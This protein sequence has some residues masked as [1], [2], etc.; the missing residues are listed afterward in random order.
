[1]AV[2]RMASE[3]EQ[4]LNNVYQQAGVKRQNPKV[5]DELAKSEAVRAQA[6]EKVQT[7]KLAVEE[8]QIAKIKGSPAGNEFSVKTPDDEKLPIKGRYRVVE[9]ADLLSSR[10]EGYDAALQPRDRARAAS[11]QQI[12]TIATRL[13]PELLGDSLTSDT[14]SP[15][16]DSRG[17]VLSGNGRTEAI[18]QAYG[19]EDNR[20]GAYKDHLVANADAY[21]L[22]SDQINGM[23]N[24]VLVREATDFGKLSAEEF[25]RRSNKQQV[26]GMSDAENASADAKFLI[27]NPDVFQLLNPSESGDVL[28]ASNREFVSKFIDS[29]GDRA[30]LVSKDGSGYN[31]AKLTPRIRNAILAAVVGPDNRPLIDALVEDNEGIKKVTASLL[32]VAPKLARLQGGDYDI[33]PDLT[34]ALT[35]LTALRQSGDTVENFLGQQTLFGDAARTAASDLILRTLAG[36]KSTKAINEFLG[37]YADLAG[38]I[39]T[40]T[41]DMFNVE[42]PTRDE[43]LTKASASKPAADSGQADLALGKPPASDGKPGQAPAPA[44]E[45]PAKV[46]P[47]QAKLDAALSP[48]ERAELDAIEKELKAKADIKSAIGNSGKFS[49]QD[50]SLLGTPSQEKTPEFKK[51][52][53][54]SKVVDENGKPKVMYHGTPRSGFSTFDR[55]ASGRDGLDSLGSWFTNSPDQARLYSGAIDGSAIYPVHLSIKNPVVFFRTADNAAKAGTEFRRLTALHDELKQNAGFTKTEYEEYIPINA[56]VLKTGTKSLTRPEKQRYDELNNLSK[57]RWEQVNE[58]LNGRDLND[59]LIDLK[60]HVKEQG[61]ENLRQSLIDRG[62]D[63]IILQNTTGDSSGFERPP[64]DMYIAFHPEQIKSATGNSGAFDPTNPSILG[65]PAEGNPV[66]QEFFT[67]GSRL[68]ALYAKTGITD[69]DNLAQTVLARL[70]NNAK[71]SL[72][73]WYNGLRFVQGVDASKLDTESNVQK[74]YDSKYADGAAAG[75]RAIPG[76]VG[77][78]G[79][80]RTPVPRVVRQELIPAS[81]SFVGTDT[82]SSHAGWKLDADQVLGANTILSH[83]ARNPTGGAFLLGDGTGFGKTAQIIAVFDQY[84]KMHPGATRLYVTQNKQMLEG[85]WKNDNQKMGVD[86]KAID[87][88]TY[89]GLDKLTKRD[90]DLVIFDEAHNLK[91][92]EA[93]KSFAAARIRAKHTLFSTATPMDRPTGAAYFLAK[94]TG[95]DEV[96]VADKLGYTYQT[97]EDPYTRELISFAVLK[98]GQTWHTVFGHIMAYR[99]AA[100]SSGAMLRRE[101]PFYGK[102]EERAVNWEGSGQRLSDEI[103]EYYDD[104]IDSASTPQARR[105]YAGQKTL[106]LR[107]FTEIHKVQQTFDM[108]M[109]HLQSGGS[110][111]IMAETDKAQSFPVRIPGAEQ[112]QNEK[113]RT[114]WRLDGAITQLTKLFAEQGIPVAHVHDTRTNKVSDEVDRFQR[115]EVRVVLATPKSG[116]AGINLDDIIG[117]RPRL[118]IAMS[119]ELAGD[120]FDQVLGRI[121]RKTTQSESVVWLLHNPSSFADERSKDIRD[122]KI[123]T[124]RAIQGGEDV[125]YSGYEGE[126]DGPQGSPIELT[127]EQQRLEGMA[128]MTRARMDD[129][130]EKGQ[131]TQTHAALLSKIESRLDLLSQKPEKDQPEEESVLGSPAQALRDLKNE[132]YNI[133]KFKGFNRVLNTWVGNRQIGIG[134]TLEFARSIEKEVPKRIRRIGIS[135]WIDAAGDIPT[136]QK[137]LAAQTTKQGKREYAAALNLTPAEIATANRVKAWFKDQFDEAVKGGIIKLTA[138]LEDYITHIVKRQYVGGGYGSGGG[139]GSKIVKKFKF[140]AQRTFPN[141]FELEQAGYEMRTKDAAEIVSIYGTHKTNAI[142]TRRFVR[143]LLAEKNEAGE[144]VAHLILG[145]L[146]DDPALPANYV[147][148]PDAAFENGIRYVPVG[149]P[150][151]KGWAWH[152]NSKE[153][154]KPVIFQGEVGIH[155]DYLAHILN[156]IGRSEIRNWY[157]SP[158][159]HGANILKAGVKLL[160][161]S[162][163]IVKGTMLGGISSFHA[164][165]EIKRAAGNRVFINP[166]PGFVKAI[167]WSDPKT[168]KM[169]RYGVML[170]G[171]QDAINAFAEGLGSRSLIDMIPG[172]GE[173]GS[174]LERRTSIG[175]ASRAVA[176]YTFHSLI[177]S[178]KWHTFNAL[179]DRNLGIFENEIKSGK[180]TEDDVG[181]LTAHQVNARFGHLN[182]AD[183]NIDPTMWHA[184]GWAALA[185]DFFTSNVIN[186]GQDIKGAAGAKTGREPFIA[187]AFT[188]AMIYTIS[189]VLNSLLDDDPHWTSE[190]FSVMYNG[191]RHTMRNEAEDLWR[192]YQD[193]AKFGMS[194]LSPLAGSMVEA[195]TGRNWRGEKVTK[196]D[197]FLEYLTKPIPISGRWIPMFR[198]LV[199]HTATGKART[200]TTM[201]EFL[202][203]QG[204]QVSRYSPINEAYSLA[205]EYKKAIGVKEDTGTYPVSDYQ[206]MRYALEDGNRVKAKEEYTKLIQLK[207]KDPTRPNKGSSTIRLDGIDKVQKGFRESMGGPWTKSRDMDEAFEK[208]LKGKA[209]DRETLKKAI[210]IKE[211]TYRQFCRMAGIPYEPLFGN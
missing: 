182:L 47:L 45:L 91:N 123:Q 99:D 140:S 5:T 68:M 147:K 31:V 211:R 127:P 209:D 108:A 124:L 75:G 133:P 20:G 3:A 51:W 12:A 165:H 181:Y 66:D 40:T 36:A 109:K 74:L 134:K 146:H 1:M 24:P 149:H 52:F 37:G 73:S 120:V 50:E 172:L 46:D 18:R 34:R 156:A 92:G 152:G 174:D 194:R 10:D 207:G 63:G 142:E 195:G 204:I 72:I 30:E 128:T 154:G 136:L 93:Q 183:L 176:D 13:D 192:L 131:P 48:E 100:I 129:A 208:S 19:A 61:A 167:D 94:I 196:M 187:L 80:K 121:S 7:E 53:G 115:G 15:I 59:T 25:A 107:R 168:H 82:Y 178:L 126:Q 202:S 35:D 118:M 205:G 98:P 199:E 153:T 62:Y 157:D 26:L 6:A 137:W 58:A 175:R 141:M 150:A 21:G 86:H 43:L 60:R 135:L 95:E 83:F 125:D 11:M 180:V 56:K 151:F 191:K 105:N 112:G 145:A 203:S 84:A 171:D 161:Q 117:N 190:P 184:L 103:E 111:V 143:S 54:D 16:I 138:F 76:A 130:R 132:V 85:S 122:K 42:N 70:G 65:A 39:D 78:N 159:S 2:L 79:G 113:G 110:I 57:S 169:V 9:S 139:L 201:D 38:K 197:T 144:S 160:D 177:P 96:S 193:W 104:L 166:L 101:Y 22:D 102:V 158:G 23:K 81:R 14:G 189:R 41:G 32:I 64:A 69:F 210:Q 8:A 87:Q 106:S 29:T 162:Q 163:S 4:R 27:S 88:A 90:Y 179:F 44:D 67:K 170:G 89:S 188:A 33:S 77:G 116:G 164:V 148:D 173:K 119:P 49:S 97:R 71:S 155:P 198:W 28:A 17:M 206:Q 185:P 200:V 114:V 55:K 186:Y